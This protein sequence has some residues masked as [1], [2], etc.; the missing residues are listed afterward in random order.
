MDGMFEKWFD[1]ISQASVEDKRKVDA[2]EMLMFKQRRVFAMQKREFCI[3][4]FVKELRNPL[5]REGRLS[6]FISIRMNLGR[7]ENR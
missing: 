3:L 1:K 5:M 4:L 2:T 6:T 7:S